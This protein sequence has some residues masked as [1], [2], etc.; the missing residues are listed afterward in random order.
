[1]FLAYPISDFIELETFDD[2]SEDIEVGVS[3]DAWFS[4]ASKRT[5][6]RGYWASCG[7]Q[8]IEEY[9]RYSLKLRN[10]RGM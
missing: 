5:Y 3:I 10:W 8:A 7:F 4:N 9:Q 2:G 6:A 1:M